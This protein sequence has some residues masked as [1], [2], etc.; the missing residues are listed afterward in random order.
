MGV[1]ITDSGTI[2]GIKPCDD[3]VAEASKTEAE[4]NLKVPG[5]V[6]PIGKMSFEVAK[7]REE[8]KLKTS[9]QLKEILERQEKI[10]NNKRLVNK[11]PD[12]G[13]KAK[14]TRTLVID[15]LKSKEKIDSLEKEMVKMKI[16]TE[17]MEWKNT[18]LDSD[19][20]SDPEVDGVQKNPLSV[21]AEG[22]VPAKSSK[23]KPVEKMNNSD[24][25]LFAIR[26]ADKVDQ[27][28]SKKNFVPYQSVKNCGLSVEV[29]S[30]LSAI[31]LTY[32]A[33]NGNNKLPSQRTP[34]IPLP[35][36]YSC[37]TK[38]LS[39]SESLKLQQDQDKK[40][41]DI[42][43]QHAAERLAASKGLAKLGLLDSVVKGQFEEYRNVH[44]ESEEEQDSGDE[45]HG[46]VGVHQVL[47]D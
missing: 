42:Q 34:S 40:L 4:R 5:E 19:D 27:T 20:D 31:N 24:L 38:Q 36:V 15:L 11:L 9:T 2:S 47:G 1:V 16:N 22:V 45:G 10:L 43:I 23:G 13:E 12:K 26:E 30:K 8:M 35:P 28:N 29:K 37:T 44:E 3:F 18:L 41:K 33:S 7:L 39:L 25:E 17:A 21:L 32:P 46:V 14:R 6:L